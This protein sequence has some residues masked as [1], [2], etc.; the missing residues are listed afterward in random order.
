[1]NKRELENSENCII[2][3]VKGKESNYLVIA[4]YVDLN[5]VMLGVR[6]SYSNDDTII[7]Y[8][9]KEHSLVSSNPSDVLYLGTPKSYGDLNTDALVR[10]DSE[11]TFPEELD[12]KNRGSEWMEAQKRSFL[13]I[14]PDVHGYLKFKATMEL[15]NYYL[16][17][18]TSIDPLRNKKR[19][20]QMRETNPSYDFMASIES[21]PTTFAKQLAIDVRKQINAVSTIVYHGPVIYLDEDKTSEFIVRSREKFSYTFPITDTIPLFVK[22]KK[23]QVQQEYRFVVSTPYRHRTNHILLNTSDDLRKLFSLVK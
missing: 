15:P 3:F 13:E 17:Y 14:S 11:G 8:S 23:Y 20:D 4:Q 16:L 21:P 12:W 18:C 2:E 6:H 1:M 7:K 19:Q 9:K 5:G 10:D 22:D